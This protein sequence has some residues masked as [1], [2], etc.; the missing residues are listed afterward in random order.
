MSIK[1]VLILG[2]SGS[3]GAPI[4]A[5][6]LAEPIFTVTI[7]SREKSSAEFPAGIP[8][9]RVS[10]EFTT[11]ELTE[12]FHG[13][14]AVVVALSTA[15]VTVEGKE[16]GNG[17]KGLAFRLIDAAVAAGVKRFIPSEYGANNLDP[18]ARTLVP[19][20]DRK[21]EML[22]Y[23]IGS[24]SSSLHLTWTSICCG[25]WLDW[26]LDP[27]KS[28]DFLGIDVKGR[29]AIVYDSG[30]K[31]FSVTTSVNTG[32][33]VAKTL[34]NPSLTANR[35]IFLSDFT[36]STREIVAELESQIGEKFDIDQ[37]DSKPVIKEL[38][39]RFDKGEWEATV[40]LTS[41]SFG[42]DVDV[43][44]NYE[45]EQ[46]RSGSSNFQQ[47]SAD[48]ISLPR[49]LDIAIRP[50]EHS[51]SAPPVDMLALLKLNAS[52]LISTASSSKSRSTIWLSKTSSSWP[53]ARVRSAA[54]TGFSATA[55]RTV[56]KKS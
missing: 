22:E 14:D 55:T 45:K 19:I 47:T 28:G 26:A 5:A 11:E 13:Q 25:S 30:L 2:A 17:E 20:Y 46:E 33:A 15:P 12:A 31:T 56:F 7:L 39:E 18:R 41:I 8:V 44:Y 50:R 9:K 40:A 6:L 24:A 51:R 53:M 32:L 21:G 35:Q 48:A 52:T 43:G 37:K 23:L 16:K 27:S 49:R 54:Y 10:D 3:V 42:A 1:S 38:R 29:K 36:T 4:L 34:R